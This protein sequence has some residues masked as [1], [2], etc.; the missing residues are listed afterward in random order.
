[1]I[2]HIVKLILGIFVFSMILIS[3]FYINICAA[4]DNNGQNKYV[5]PVFLK[6]AANTN[7]VILA[8]KQEFTKN[9]NL[10]TDQLTGCLKKLLN[11]PEKFNV[12]Y[13]KSYFKP[14]GQGET[15]NYDFINITLSNALFDNLR[16]DTASINFKT[17]SID[18]YK[19]FKEGKIRVVSQDE[20]YTKIVLLEKDLNEYL[21]KKSEK[22]KVQKPFAKL[23]NKIMKIGG[24]FRY[25]IM[26]IDF[27]ASGDFKVVDG[28]KI[29]FNV[30]NMNINRM[31]VPRN[32]RRQVEN[33]N[34][35]LDLQKFPFK[36]ILKSIEI[37][38]NSLIFAS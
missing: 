11:D 8:V 3:P 1:M 22:I 24:I 26:V 9:P 5:E 37:E 23:E 29:N 27:N 4:A 2:Q 16:I 28:S 33:L 6:N 10:F 32:L 7:E 12:E 17:T 31:K 36:L 13:S 14:A 19:L 21:V 34:P 35:I 25:G 15:I 30:K 20:I 38:N 18:I